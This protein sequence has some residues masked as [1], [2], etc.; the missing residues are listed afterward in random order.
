MFRN[1]NSTYN[2]LSSSPDYD[3]ED[4]L[5]VKSTSKRSWCSPRLL[6][7]IVLVESIVLVWALLGPPHPPLRC[8]SEST[9]FSPAN[10]AVEYHVRT[11]TYDPKF[12][13]PPS[14]ELDAYW[15]ELYSVGVSRIPK[16]QAALL[17]N[18]RSIPG[19]GTNRILQNMIRQ[20]L[21]SDYY[22]D[23]AM[24]VDD[25][26][27]H[28]DHCVDWI[29]QALIWGWEE[30]EQKNKFRKEIAHTCRDFGRIREWAVKHRLTNYDAS[31][32]TDDDGIVIPIIH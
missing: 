14:D 2:R 4:P 25:N 11:F 24:N 31:I 23:M 22:A 7:L 21:H 26:T 28:V 20:A 12:H 15:Q 6:L 8:P 32:R 30:K 1:L 17:P 19:A 9:L 27:G 29:R 16:N 5:D 10:E 3:E 13:L 18:R